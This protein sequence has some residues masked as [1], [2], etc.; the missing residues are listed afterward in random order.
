MIDWPSAI[1]LCTMWLSI[2]S[3]VI[4]FMYFASK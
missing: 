4:G 2:A 1:V 3:I